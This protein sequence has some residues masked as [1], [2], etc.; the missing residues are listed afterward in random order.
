MPSDEHT[1]AIVR[2]AVK[3]TLAQT[4][5]LAR[6]DAAD[7]ALAAA[8]KAVNETH[9]RLF[10]QLGYD[11]A[12]MKDVRRL[13]DTLGFMESLKRGSSNLAAAVT[14]AIAVAIVL[15]IMAWIAIGARSSLL[16]GAPP[17]PHIK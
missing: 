12:N 2:A 15:A 1:R 9:V 4:P 3:E 11:L 17:P 8:N 5:R 7:I 14:K 10:A 13:R 6:E 16:N